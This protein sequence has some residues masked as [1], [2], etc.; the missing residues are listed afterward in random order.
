MTKVWTRLAPLAI[1]Q[2]TLIPAHVPGFIDLCEL[3]VKRQKADRKATD[4]GVSEMRVYLQLV[5]Q[6]EGLKARFRLNPFGKAAAPAAKP[7]SVNPADRYLNALQ[8]K[9]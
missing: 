6:I 3:E 7:N 2:R 4:G 8:R 9:A 5:K 1:E